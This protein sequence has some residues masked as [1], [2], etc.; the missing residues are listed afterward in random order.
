MSGLIG[1][2]NVIFMAIPSAIV[3]IV[4]MSEELGVNFGIL[5]CFLVLAQQVSNC[6]FGFGLIK[7]FSAQ[8]IGYSFV[9]AFL[10]TV[11]SFW[12]LEPTAI[13]NANY[14]QIQEE[15]KTTGN[16]DRFIVC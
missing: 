14:T 5:N 8:K 6:L 4:I 12:I 3:S 11:A 16:G 7:L 15:S 13:D 10:A 9:P 1:I 2:S